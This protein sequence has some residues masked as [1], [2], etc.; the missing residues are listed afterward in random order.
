MAAIFLFY[1]EQFI[2]PMDEHETYF[3]V[4]VPSDD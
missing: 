2:M 4:D 3:S 1:L